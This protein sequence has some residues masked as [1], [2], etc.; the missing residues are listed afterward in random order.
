MTEGEEEMMARLAQDGGE[1][2]RRRRSRARLFEIF[3]V[4]SDP[5]R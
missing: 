1:T 4:F 2:G 5:V 3:S